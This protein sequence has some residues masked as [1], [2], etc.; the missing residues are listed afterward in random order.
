MYENC[1]HFSTFYVE[2][3]RILVFRFLCFEWRRE[4][5][6]FSWYWN[7]WWAL[8]DRISYICHALW[9]FSDVG[10]FSGNKVVNFKVLSVSG[11]SIISRVGIRKVFLTQ[12]RTNKIVSPQATLN[13]WMALSMEI[14]MANNKFFY[15]PN[16][17]IYSLKFNFSANCQLAF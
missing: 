9:H 13:L 3:K 1:S 17:L 2:W 10:S 14:L 15:L 8:V 7:H 5:M 16:V 4:K 6:G 11:Y 12:N